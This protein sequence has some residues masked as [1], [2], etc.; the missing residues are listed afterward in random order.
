[1]AARGRTWNLG[2]SLKSYIDPRVYYQW[3]QQV[4]YDVLARYYPKSLQKKFAWVREG[5]GDKQT[6]GRG[7]LDA[8]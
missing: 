2:T 3:G 4:E 8:E 1:V 5:Q 7:G 6:E